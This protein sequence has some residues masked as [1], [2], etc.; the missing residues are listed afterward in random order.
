MKLLVFVQAVLTLVVSVSPVSVARFPELEDPTAVVIDQD[1]V[2]ITDGVTIYIYSLKDFKLQKKFGK[3][4][5]GAQ[6]FKLYEYRSK[7]IYINVLPNRIM[8]ESFGRISYFT[9]KGNF[10]ELIQPRDYFMLA[11]PV[12]ENF[13][14]QRYT[15]RNNTWYICLDLYNSRFERCKEILRLKD[16]SQHRERRKLLSRAR[17]YCTY[18]NKLFTAVKKDFIIDVFDHR[19]ERLYSINQEYQKVKVTKAYIKSRLENAK[20][21]YRERPVA[22]EYFEMSALFPDYFPAIAHLY[23]E[24]GVLYVRTWKREKEKTEFYLFDMTGKFIKKILL[25]LAQ[26]NAAVYYPFTFHNSKL[27]QLVK[28][29][30]KKIW[31]LHEFIVDRIEIEEE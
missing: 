18:A 17:T 29:R 15:R 30:D 23:A 25:P 27:Y 22:Y 21:I 20:E 10:L 7:P 11:K 6:D 13:T 14:A 26:K 16:S 9:R 8:V 24:D 4:G 1:Q 28:D 19:G 12:G 31:E 5:P 3:S 2:F